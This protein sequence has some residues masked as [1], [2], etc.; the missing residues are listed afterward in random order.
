MP[1]VNVKVIEGVLS[2]AEKNEVIQGVT[3][4]M[5]AVKGE[6]FRELVS[7]VVTEVKSGSWA[8]GGRVL[9]T[10]EVRAIAAGKGKTGRSPGRAR[11]AAVRARPPRRR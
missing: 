11:R 2:D 7:V 9:T 8:V 10:A 6:N 3:D 4:A 5:V 1:F